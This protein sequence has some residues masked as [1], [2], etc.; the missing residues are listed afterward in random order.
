MNPGFLPRKPFV[1]LRAFQAAD[2]LIFFGR[3]DQT[4]ELLQKLHETHFVAVLGPS[5]SGKSSL[6]LA[7]LIP[8]LMAGFLVKKRD[9]WHIAT[10]RPGERPLF[11]LADSLLSSI[12]SKKKPSVDADDNVT[13]FV[14]D[15]QTYGV[16]GLLNKLAPVFENSDA[17]L[18]LLVDQFEELF[19]FHHIYT[20]QREE[21]A[22]FV[23]LMLALAKQR[24]LPIFV[25]M[26]MRSDFLG[27]CTIYH[28]LPEA[29][30]KSIYL[31]PRLA[32]E[33]LREAIEVP[34]KLYGTTLTSHLLDELLSDVGYNPDHLPILQH[35]LLRIWD[36]SIR[37][38]KEAIAIDIMNY[39]QI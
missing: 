37:D 36:C 14:N 23:S 35:V 30:N 20:E 19:R 26:T 4:A 32:A 1:G 25:V 11:N 12:P 7:G 18:L 3:Q 16:D 21:A 6:I 2:S 10:M 22:K 34:I 33:Q 29:I 15:I 27:D 31:V 8:K 17:N 39:G 9:Q 28:G 24:H 38:K 13:N 5:G